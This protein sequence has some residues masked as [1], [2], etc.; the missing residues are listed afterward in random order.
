MSDKQSY[1][2]ENYNNLLNS[3]FDSPEYFKIENQHIEVIDLWPP[4]IKTMVPLVMVPGWATATEV[5]R[6]NAIALALLGRRII[7]PN[8]PH[9]LDIKPKKYV[10]YP[11]A[12]LRK[13]AA[14]LQA[15]EHKN[16]DQVDAVGHSEAGI[17]L[18][19]AAIENSNKFRNLVLIS[20]AGLIGKD[21]LPRLAAGFSHDIAGQTIRAFLQEPS[22]LGK[23]GTAYWEAMKIIIQ[24]PQKTWQEIMAMV[25]YQITDLLLELKQQGHGIS[26]IH[27]THDKT[28][29]MKLIQKMVKSN[30]VDGLISIEGSHNELYLKPQSITYWVD[31]LLDTMEKRSTIN[32]K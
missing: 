16:L 20:P 17:F 29:P 24:D 15:I 27:T 30:M 19:I 18:T 5:L 14:I 25:N 23:I 10:N 22:R 26:I 3:Q 13:T 28:F 1:D 7:L 12:E 8:S 31:N 2:I 6:E 21:K 11:L 9:G 32:K 4:K